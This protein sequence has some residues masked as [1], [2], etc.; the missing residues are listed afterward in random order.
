M[1][2]VDRA[3]SVICGTVSLRDPVVIKLPGY[4]LRNSSDSFSNM[5]CVQI[6]LELT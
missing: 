3:H 5:N 1:W 4:N 2:N 6:E